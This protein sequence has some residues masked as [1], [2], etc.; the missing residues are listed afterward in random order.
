MTVVVEG[1]AVQDSEHGVAAPVFIQQLWVWLLFRC[2]NSQEGPR[3]SVCEGRSGNAIGPNPA[4]P[5]T[6]PHG[7]PSRC[8]AK[9]GE[10][11]P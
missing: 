3:V 10:T 6:G 1:P 9:F 7:L 4:V 11:D 8:S 5:M 2:R